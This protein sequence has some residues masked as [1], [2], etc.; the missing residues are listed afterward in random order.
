MRKVA[1]VVLV[2]N[3]VAETRVP[4]VLYFCGKESVRSADWLP[5]QNSSC[6][7]GISHD[8]LCPHVVFHHD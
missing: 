2:L 1:V 8:P 3:D 5:R 7:R 4:L 6:S